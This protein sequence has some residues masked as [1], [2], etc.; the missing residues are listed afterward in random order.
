M[1]EADKKLQQ[2]NLNGY[3]IEK[4]SGK[5]RNCRR[6]N[7]PIQLQFA[8]SSCQLSHGELT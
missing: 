3:R 7:E 4:Q 8:H 2:F 1:E 5:Y 6:P